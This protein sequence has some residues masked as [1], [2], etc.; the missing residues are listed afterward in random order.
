VLRLVKAVFTFD[1]GADYVA[2]KIQRHSGVRV[3]I[4]DWQ[5]RHP[6]LASPV[7]AIRY[8]RRGAFR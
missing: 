2:W 3:D 7:L 6:L 5:R 8:W 4:S 1:G